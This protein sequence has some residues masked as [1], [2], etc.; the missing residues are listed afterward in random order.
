MTNTS[1]N[2]PCPCGS[3]KK[4]KKCCLRSV[5]DNE[6]EYRR[7]RQV[8]AGLIPRLLDHA[9]ETLGPNSLA[10]AWEEF[11]DYEPV[12]DLDPESPMNQVFKPWYIFNWIHEVKAKGKRV[13]ETTIAE[14][15]LK[16]HKKSLTPDEETFLLSAI[17]CPY[18]LCEVV[19]VKPGVGMKLVDMFRRDKHEVVERLASQSLKRGDILYC[20]TTQVG[21][22]RS[23]I[24]TSPFALRPIAK[25]DVLQLRKEI[26][27]EVGYETLT[28]VDLYEFEA[29]IRG[30]YLDLVA[31]MF[32]PP[33]LVNTDG[34]PLLPQKLYFDLES[35]HEAFHALKDLAEA[36]D[37]SDQLEGATIEGGRVVLA[38]IP[39]SGGNR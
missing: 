7:Q 23:N 15:F 19:E 31:E 38:E 17:R 30:L 26:V 33:Q 8:E 9:Y 35:V 14:S 24:S 2:D 12:E 29:D 32:A 27:A 3:G 10:D 22:I 13:V 20:A 28:E 34:E 36:A 39:W 4:Y 37:E 18:S 6:F 5:E 25:R 1:R 16:K 11:N 21:E